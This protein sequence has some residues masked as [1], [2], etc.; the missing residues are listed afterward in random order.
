MTYKPVSF[1][2]RLEPDP[3]KADEIG[4]I[5]RCAQEFDNSGTYLQSFFTPALAAWVAEQIRN[6]FPPDLYGSLQ[7]QWAQSAEAMNAAKLAQNA[8]RETE[9]A[10]NAAGRQY[11]ELCEKVATEEAKWHERLADVQG[12]Y[13]KWLDD[14]NAQLGELRH[15]NADYALDM[16]DLE[17]TVAARDAEIIRLKAKLYDQS[18]ELARLSKY[19]TEL[20]MQVP[21]GP[22]VK[23]DFNEADL[24]KITANN[25]AA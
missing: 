7:Y 25:G 17:S 20:A 12:Q 3:C 13:Q 23:I 10:A 24:A 21:M 9:I 11:A 1:N 5:E 14:K 22:A 6:D 2:V 19:A 16:A 4:L 18:E 8:Q 15:A